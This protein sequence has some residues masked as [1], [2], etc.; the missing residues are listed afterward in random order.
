MDFFEVIKNRHCVRSFDPNEKVSDEDIA[1][2][3]DAGRRAPS[4]GGIYPVEFAVIT[5]KKT[6]S[7]LTD[8]TTN[9][10][11]RMN[12]IE[13]APIVIVIYADVE[14]TA[15]RYQNRGRGLYVIQDAAAAAENIFLATVALGLSTCWVGAFDEE[16]VRKTLNLKPDER[17][18][19]IMPIGYNKN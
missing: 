10:L 3:V 2:I 8:S 11:R 18:M 16:H 7:E 4:A 12:F 1:K 15:T 5:D 9:V 13:E 6:I 19:V 17:P 14:R